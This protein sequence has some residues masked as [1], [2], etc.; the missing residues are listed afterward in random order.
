VLVSQVGVRIIVGEFQRVLDG[1]KI[2]S[3]RCQI[4]GQ[5]TDLIFFT[6]GPMG[7]VTDK[8]EFFAQR[9]M[10]GSSV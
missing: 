6:S 3:L 5:L 8:T 10:C 2:C 7:T 9:L 1:H 4:G